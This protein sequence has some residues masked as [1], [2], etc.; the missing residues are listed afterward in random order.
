MR[1]L[2]KVEK[3]VLTLTVYANLRTVLFLCFRLKSKLSMTRDNV[4]QHYENIRVLKF[5]PYVL[6]QMEAWNYSQPVV[7]NSFRAR[8]PLKIISTRNI[9]AGCIQWVTVNISCLICFIFNGQLFKHAFAWYRALYEYLGLS[10]F[11]TLVGC[12]KVGFSKDENAKLS[13]F[14]LSAITMTYYNCFDFLFSNDFYSVF[15]RARCKKKDAA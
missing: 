1:D 14:T 5:G 7:L 3:C 6:R 15:G 2:R 9:I 10:V 12:I 8:C 11:H 13:G 4:H